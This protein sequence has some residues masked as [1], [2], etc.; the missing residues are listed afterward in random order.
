MAEVFGHEPS[1]VRFSNYWGD[2]YPN[3]SMVIET[4]TAPEPFS[5]AFHVFGVERTPTELVWYVDGVERARTTEGAEHQDPRFLSLA[6]LIGTGAEPS[7]PP[8]ATTPWP[9]EM[10]IDWVRVWERE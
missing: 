6:I 3:H 9:I 1:V 10:A 2:K 7:D 8:D 5:A 4:Y